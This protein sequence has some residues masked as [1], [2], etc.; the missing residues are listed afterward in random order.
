VQQ[1]GA[2]FDLFWFC[3]FVLRHEAARSLEFDLIWRYDCSLLSPT[4]EC[5]TAFVQ[6]RTSCSL[7]SHQDRCNRAP[8]SCLDAA[9]LGLARTVYIYAV[10]LRIFDQTP[11]KNTVFTPNV[12]K[13]YANPMQK[14]R[15]H[16]K[17]MWFSPTL[18]VTLCHYC[19]K[20]LSRC[21]LLVG[22]YWKYRIHTKRMWFW[23]TLCV[24]LCHY[25]AKWLQWLQRGVT[26]SQVVWLIGCWLVSASHK[27][28]HKLRKKKKQ[29]IDPLPLLCQ[30]AVKVLPACRCV[31][32]PT[33]GQPYAWP[34]ALIVPNGCQ[35]AACSM[36]CLL[37][38]CLSRCC[39][40]NVLPAQCAPCSMCSLL[41]GAACSR[42]CLLVGAYWN[43]TVVANIVRLLNAGRSAEAGWLNDSSTS[44]KHYS[45]AECRPQCGS[46]LAQWLFY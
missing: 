32:K 21:C 46:Q 17:R 1:L 13:P 35:G 41:V 26:F 42:C 24:T 16:T 45:L 2:C 27:L 39:L 20:W 7:F 9:W 10:Y 33:S 40:L 18:C 11:A 4:A 28:I 23:P 29:S 19:A 30:M 22:A 15:I 25:C 37:R 5:W 38:C 31:L 43:L 3:L 8:S 44:G 12:C 6:N 36:C 14:Y 34:C